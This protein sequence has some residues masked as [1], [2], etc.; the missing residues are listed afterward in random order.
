MESNLFQLLQ[1]YDQG[2]NE[3]N[4]LI[5][6][7]EEVAPDKETSDVDRYSSICRAA[8]V[9]ICARNEGYI[10]ELFRAYFDDINQN[11]AFNEIKEGLVLNSFTKYYTDKEKFLRFYNDKLK[12]MDFKLDYEEFLNPNDER[13]VKGKNITTSYITKLANK[14]G[15]LQL[16][17]SLE[18]SN[19]KDV[20]SNDKNE[21]IECYN[22]LLE[23]LI[24]KSKEFPYEFNLLDYRLVLPKKNVN[25]SGL[26][27][28]FLDNLI[29]KRNQI[30][31]G[32]S[33][34]NLVNTNDLKDF[35]IKSKILSLVLTIC[36]TLDYHSK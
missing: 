19:L 6:M 7:A 5:S 10:K 13:E 3:I 14:I 25:N 12:V 24:E 17:E 8:T 4:I 22:K 31:H 32:L 29:I 26:W 21:N 16:I 36:L 30:A 9:L 1:Q 33:R 20:F 23:Y 15:Y 28:G 11:I 34:D 2:W 27:Q 35:L 18:I